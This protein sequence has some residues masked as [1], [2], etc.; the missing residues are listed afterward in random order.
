ML[1]DNSFHISSQPYQ[2]EIT[3]CHQLDV[4]KVLI[5][6]MLNNN[7]FQGHMAGR[8]SEASGLFKKACP[9]PLEGFVQS[10]PEL[11]GRESRSIACCIP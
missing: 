10:C 1:R 8:I 5:L 3:E 9:E 4:K 2:D 11:C 6:R 7:N